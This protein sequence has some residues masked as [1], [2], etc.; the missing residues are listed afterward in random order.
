MRAA[1]TCL[2]LLASLSLAAQVP[3]RQTFRQWIGG[4]EMGGSSRELK[5]EGLDWV[6]Q[7]KEWITLSRLGQEIRQESTET[8]RKRPDG[9]LVFGWR[10]LL[11]AEPFEGKASWSPT[12]PRALSLQPAQGTALQKELPQGALLWPEDLDSRLKEAA[13][14]HHP[15]QATTFSFPI[16]QWVQLELEPAGPAPLPGF[17]DAFRFTGREHQGTATA[18]VEV[19]VSPTAGELKHL[20]NLGSLTLLTQRAELPA[21]KETTRGSAFFEGTLQTIPA[22]P[23]L[24]WLQSLTLHAEGSQPDLPED[25]QQTRVGKGTWLLRRALPPNQDEAS[26]SPVKGS[27]STEEARYLAPTPL[28]PFQDPAFDGLLRRMGLPAG[29]SRWELAQRVTSFVFDWVVDKDYSVGFASALEVCRNPR[30][31]CTEHGVLAV[32]LLRKL[33]VPARGVTGWV[34][35]GETLGLHFWVEVRLRDRWVP[36]DPTFDQSPASAFRLKLGDTDLADLGSVG[37]EGAAIAFSGVRWIPEKDER[38]AWPGTLEANHEVLTAPGGLQLRL[39][40]G[41]WD[42]YQGQVR[43]L[44]KWGIWSFTA[45]TRPGERQLQNARKVA[46]PTSLRTGW[47]DPAT[48]GLWMD[49]GSG[50]WI[51]WS[52]ISESEAFRLLDQLVASP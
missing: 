3:Y 21:P 28:V 19:W 39:P 47:W 9:S 51:L 42:L 25:A 29:L 44:G 43:A 41:R 8:A 20:G 52:D 17:P 6:I 15:I 4:Q 23:F 1:F 14:D 49:L 40:G 32:A 48:R 16:Q 26:Q 31:D 18:A 35:L 34:A 10:L 2:A 36:V 45:T 30:G 38:H 5:K 12:K 11:S 13:R 33:G 50:R 46:G 27:P 24:P 22:H 7:E 37:W